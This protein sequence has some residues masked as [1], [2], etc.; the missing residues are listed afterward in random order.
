[1][2]VVV[3]ECPIILLLFFG[4]TSVPTIL[5]YLKSEYSGPSL[6]NPNVAYLVIMI[7]FQGTHF[8]V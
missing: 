3:I 1:M 2:I 5:T 4:R 8:I 7:D 6:R